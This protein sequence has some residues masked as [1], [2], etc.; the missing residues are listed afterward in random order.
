MNNDP[1][2]IRKDIPPPVGRRKGVLTGLTAVVLKMQ[3]GDSILVKNAS[4]SAVGAFLYRLKFG[5]KNFTC[6]TIGPDV[7][8]WRIA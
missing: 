8:V 7:R 6:R 4:I 1:F 3:I 5:G 2:P